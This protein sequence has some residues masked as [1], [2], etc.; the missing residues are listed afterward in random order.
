[1]KKLICFCLSLFLLFTSA[2]PA[3]VADASSLGSENLIS[4]NF[5]YI[6]S[7]SAGLGISSSGKAHYSGSID[8][9]SNSYTVAL[10]VSLQ[11]STSN[12]W[13]TVKSWSGSGSGQCG[14]IV[15]GYYYVDNGT[16][17]VCSSAKVYKSTGLLLETASFYSAY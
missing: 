2:I 12:G 3:S 13:T 5:T 15:E 17:R 6:W 8:A 9:S 16:Y 1:M 10:T 4:P 11:K 14:L 7:I